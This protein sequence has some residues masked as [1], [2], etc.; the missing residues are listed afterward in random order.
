MDTLVQETT[1]PG[2]E[3]RSERR[4][5]VRAA[6]AAAVGWAA[7]S[8][9]RNSC[10]TFF[11]A[12][13]LHQKTSM[14]EAPRRPC[15]PQNSRPCWSRF[16]GI[17]LRLYMQDFLCRARTPSQSLTEAPLAANSV[18]EAWKCTSLAGSKHFGLYMQGICD[19]RTLG[20]PSKRRPGVWRRRNTTSMSYSGFYCFTFSSISSLSRLYIFFLE[21]YTFSFLYAEGS[22]FIIFFPFHCF[23]S[24]LPL[25]IDLSY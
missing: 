24:P 13:E 12:Q 4:R 22:A 16:Q 15:K 23:S 14:T 25:S 10:R 3:Y 7:A 20:T 11:A 5:G 21:H 17:V 1:K 6:A 8:P 19:L 18:T 2:G 9:K